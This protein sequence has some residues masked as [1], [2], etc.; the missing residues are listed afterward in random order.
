MGKSGSGP[1]FIFI[2]SGK[3]M[4]ENG[5]SMHELGFLSLYI[6]FLPGHVAIIHSFSLS[7]HF[8]M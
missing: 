4:K 1:S 5:T 3:T 8:I 7:L 2:I 6:V